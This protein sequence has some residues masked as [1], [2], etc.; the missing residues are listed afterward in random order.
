MNLE[1][2]AKV[3]WVKRLKVYEAVVFIH[4]QDE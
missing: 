2:E 1:V 3:L 4:V